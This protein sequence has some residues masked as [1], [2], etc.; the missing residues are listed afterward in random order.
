MKAQCSFQGAPASIQRRR[1]SFCSAVRVL[2]DIAGGMRKAGSS[3]VIRLMIRLSAGFPGA[4]TNPF[5][6]SAK[7][8]SR[9]S[10]RRSAMRFPLSGPWQRKQL[11]ERIGRTW[12]WKSGAGEEVVVVAAPADTRAEHERA[13]NEAKSPRQPRINRIVIAYRIEYLL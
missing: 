12:R 4:M 11:S 7:A 8:P 3:D 2:C 13:A 1:I 10:S 5:L 6:R 9:T